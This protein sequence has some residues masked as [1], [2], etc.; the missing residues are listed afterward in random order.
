MDKYNSGTNNALRHGTRRIDAHD[1]LTILAYVSGHHVN[2]PN[3]AG[4]IG[5]SESTV[6]RI[7]RSA[8]DQ[9]GVEIVWRADRSMKG[10]GEFIIN[11]WG[12]FDQ[13]AVL[14]LFPII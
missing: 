12:V 1:L 13:E 4:Y 10:Q 8:R 3:I 7:I 6:R 2:A 14:R 5:T 9:Y 11:D